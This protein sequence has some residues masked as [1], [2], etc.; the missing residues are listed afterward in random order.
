M[1]I[2]Q[3]PITRERYRQVVARK[4]RY[5]ERIQELEAL[6]SGTETE[7]VFDKLHLRIRA[8]EEKLEYFREAVQNLKLE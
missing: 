6:L 4:Q 5:W 3:W 1:K 2:E 8:L 7:E